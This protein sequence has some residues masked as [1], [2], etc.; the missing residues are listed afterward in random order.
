VQLANAPQPKE[1][2]GAKTPLSTKT[3]QNPKGD[4]M[5]YNKVTLIGHV[6]D[7]P[8]INTTPAG[9]SYAT[10]YIATN[11]LMG[12]E[13]DGT[14]KTVPNF[15]QIKAWDSDRYKITE[16][17]KRDIQKG[18]FT[19]IEG[20]LINSRWEQD[21][22]IH[23][24]CS[25]QAKLVARMEPKRKDTAQTDIQPDP[26]EEQYEMSQVYEAGESDDIPPF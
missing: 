14:W 25:V 12:Q 26:T 9:R 17:I 20:T 13:P 5:D 23:H 11:R 1:K 2:R 22:V 24:G 15:T 16:K 3:V 8:K 21:G 19:M 10:F 6:T 18:T 4:K 7:A